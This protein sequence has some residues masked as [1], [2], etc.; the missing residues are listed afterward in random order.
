[1]KNLTKA[2]TVSNNVERI[3]LAVVAAGLKPNHPV[4]EAG[5]GTRLCYSLPVPEQTDAY[6]NRLRLDVELHFDNPHDFSEEVQAAINYVIDHQNFGF[7]PFNVSGEE[8]TD[9]VRMDHFEKELAECVA[10]VRAGIRPVDPREP[11]R[12][13]LVSV[14]LACA[15]RI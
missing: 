6:N 15:N 7:I 13:G 11:A 3:I 12:V 8:N 4:Q 1:M 10:R 5:R 9:L 2:K 14:R